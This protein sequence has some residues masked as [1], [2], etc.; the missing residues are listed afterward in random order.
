[1]TL[2]FE[3]DVPQLVVMLTHNDLTVENAE[4]VFELCK[5]SRARFW[6]M[7]EKPLPR[8][9]MKTLFARMKECGKTTALEVVAYD[10]EGALQGARLAAECEC[11]ILMGTKFHEEAAHYCHAHGIA[12][13]PFVGTIEGRPSV[14]AG[15]IDEIVEEARDVL[16]RGADGV[17]LL[18][19]RYTG[20]ATALNEAVARGVDAPVCIAGSIDGTRRLDEVKAAGAQAFTIGSAFFDGKFGGSLPEQID[21]VCSHMEG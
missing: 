16:A 19:Y 17:D 5:D 20:D 13:M 12:Y 15:S 6:G 7:K 8:E 1:M 3:S 9:R 2:T 18:G 4:E 21:A 10:R 11:D 14:L